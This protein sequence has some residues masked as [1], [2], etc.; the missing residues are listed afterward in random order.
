MFFRVLCSVC[1]GE[2]SPAIL[3]GTSFKG[4]QSCEAVTSWGPSSHAVMTLPHEV[5]TTLLLF[6]INGDEYGHAW[7]SIMVPHLGSVTACA[8]QDPVH[9]TSSLRMNL[10]V[11]FVMNTQMCMGLYLMVSSSSTSFRMGRVSSGMVSRMYGHV[12]AILSSPAVM[13][14]LMIVVY[15]LL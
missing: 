11:I 10:Y 8:T 9:R 7:G 4:T 1:H 13:S 15:A 3:T 5:A 2:Q 12:R 14:G 6:F